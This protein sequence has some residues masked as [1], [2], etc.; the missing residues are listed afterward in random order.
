M[1]KLIYLSNSIFP[2]HLANNVHVMKMCSA[3]SSQGFEVTLL[4]KKTRPINSAELFTRYSVINNFRIKSFQLLKFPFCSVAI[5]AL[6]YI[7]FILLKKD[8]E[9]LI[10]SR[11]RHSSFILAILKI[12][13][14]YEMHGLSSSKIQSWMDSVI[15]SS[16]S[17]KI[18][19]ISASLKN[20]LLNR[21]ASVDAAKILIAH[22]GA[23][24]QGVV[25]VKPAK[26]HGLFKY[27]VG[28]VGSL[29]PGKGVEFLCEASK[30]L[31]DF[32]FHIVGGDKIAISKMVETCG[33]TSNLFFYGH[34]P[35]GETKSFLKAFDVA[36]LPNEHVVKTLDGEDIGKY[37]SPLKLFEY[38]SFD[39]K[40][41]LSDI[42]VLREVIDESYGFF[43]E[44][45]DV[46]S[47]VKVLSSTR[48]SCH[49]KG[50]KMIKEK[51]S[52]EFRSKFILKNLEL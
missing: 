22:D 28:Y 36:V 3:F 11:N 50:S 33:Q 47:L 8:R 43:F 46:S 6:A 15:C 9:T 32:G 49:K 37:T 27:N 2:S 29:F 31:P 42:P 51:Y 26:L 18:V 1:E 41:V 19:T 7:Y 13:H 20:D 30:Q 23:D 34:V 17:A 40:I 4:C 38:L 12:S 14:I 5:S 48:G 21:Y 44:P 52:W 24:V 25:N 10:Y 35:H 16:V 45:S 39:K